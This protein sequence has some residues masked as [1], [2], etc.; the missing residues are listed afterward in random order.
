MQSMPA[1]WYIVFSWP[2]WWYTVMRMVAKITA[3]S[4]A[5]RRE[6][7]YLRADVICVHVD[8]RWVL[9]RALRLAVK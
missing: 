9:L 5:H 4:A 6:T 1:F 3:L 7:V 2:N 8:R